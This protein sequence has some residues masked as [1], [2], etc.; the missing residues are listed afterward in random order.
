MTGRLLRIRGP[1]VRFLAFKLGLQ[2][3]QRLQVDSRQEY[4]CQPVH[5]LF[6]LPIPLPMERPFISAIRVSMAQLADQIVEILGFQFVRAVLQRKE[7]LP[8]PLWLILRSGNVDLGHEF[9]LKLAYGAT[10]EITD[11]DPMAKDPPGFGN[12]VTLVA[13]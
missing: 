7:F 13:S 1:R 10:S 12:L 4:L 5:C 6:A 2:N 9:Q 11:F 3:V 8:R